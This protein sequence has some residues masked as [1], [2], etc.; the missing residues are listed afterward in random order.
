MSV[1]SHSWPRTAAAL[2]IL[3]LVC[4]PAPGRAAAESCTLSADRT[5]LEIRAAAEAA[6]GEAA[7]PGATTDSIMLNFG[8]SWSLVAAN[9][10]ADG[11]LA[12]GGQ[13]FLETA[14]LAGETARSDTQVG[15]APSSVGATNLV[16]TTGISEILSL[17]FGSGAI[18]QEQRADS[19]TFSTSPYALLALG[20]GDTQT[21][22]E[23]FGLARRLGL[24]A[25]VNLNP[26]EGDG[27]GLFETEQFS[28][29]GVRMRL[30]GD[31]S[32][33][34][35][36]FGDR[37]RE[38]VQPEIQRKV[39]AQKDLF[40]AFL[41]TQ[42]GS[43]RLIDSLIGHS[44]MRPVAKTVLDYVA[45]ATG[46][47][48]SDE[49]FEG[50]VAKLVP[51]VCSQIFV[52]V[53]NGDITFGDDQATADRIAAITTE[54]LKSREKSRRL[55][56]EAITEFNTRPVVTATYNLERIA[57][58]GS[59]YSDLKLL[60]EGRLFPD[61]PYG[62]DFTLNAGVSLYHD[63]IASLGQETVRDYSG[64]ASMKW[65]LPNVFFGG[66]LQKLDP[67]DM[68]PIT[69]SASGKVAQN[70]QIDAAI[71]NVEVRLGIPLLRGF[72]VPLTFNY[73][74]RTTTSASGEFRVNVGVD[75]DSL[76]ALVLSQ[77]SKR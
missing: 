4:V 29:V 44:P 1:D 15:A 46:N 37:W 49:N 65:L 7:V 55:T 51:Q 25:T 36:A 59:D 71:G 66:F 6:L 11:L 14:E 22:F 52:P 40:D 10:A 60:G 34:T 17:A 19:V 8:G 9:A 70:E 75:F 23:R 3:A 45:E 2:F 24:S 63:P 64:T 54:I 77:L 21:T 68:S 74:T 62:F 69:L 48:E 35:R 42:E 20:Y 31:R 76:K 38:T 56:E 30:F 16:A 18:Q 73:A 33:R 57:D 39:D 5:M 58:G 72:S 50:L 67:D 12:K 27:D 28:G 43:D 53:K 32:T 26:E 41:K 61:S 47:L 13:P